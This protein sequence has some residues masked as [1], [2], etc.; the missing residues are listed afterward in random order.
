M[1][2]LRKLFG[3]NKKSKSKENKKPKIK[4]GFSK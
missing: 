4:Q 2:F 1:N 3:M